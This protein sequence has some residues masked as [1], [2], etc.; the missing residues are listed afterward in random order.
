MSWNCITLAGGHGA[1]NAAIV[2]IEALEQA[3]ADAGRPPNVNVFHRRRGDGAYV[4]HLSPT[5]SALFA[6]FL[7]T[8]AAVECAEPAADDMRIRVRL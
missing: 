7:Q 2:L 3:Y 1:E 8:T 5:A 6:E 4:F